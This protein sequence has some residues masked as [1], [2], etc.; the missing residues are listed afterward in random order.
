[1][2]VNEVLSGAGA[3]V[4]YSPDTTCG[5]FVAASQETY[6]GQACELQ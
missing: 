3:L 6:T 4:A 2:R 1:M 5:P